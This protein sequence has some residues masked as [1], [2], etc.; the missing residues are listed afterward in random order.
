[1]KLIKN[2][3]NGVVGSDIKEDINEDI[4]Y[5]LLSNNFVDDDVMW[6]LLYYSGYLTYDGNHLFIPN[7][8]V[9]T[10]WMGWIRIK[11]IKNPN[12]LLNMLLEGNLATFEK[13]FP[14]LIM[15]VL[16]YH[17]VRDNLVESN[18]HLFTV[19][20]FAQAQFCGYKVESNK[21]CGLGLFDL[22]LV[23]NEGANYLTSVIIEFKAIK[24]KYHDD[25]EYCEEI[26]SDF[27][28]EENNVES[29]L[30]KK[31]IEGF[32]QILEKKYEFDPN[33][34]S[35]KLVE[36]GIAFC[37]KQVCVVGRVLQRIGNEWKEIYC[38]KALSDH[39]NVNK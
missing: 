4:N 27:N 2:I 14:N 30:Q 7:K 5:D 8:E 28:E 9:F 18:Y 36:C 17:D 6:T 1:V 12:L 16:S 11:G 37:G 38:S 22:K 23:P 39:L 20:L 29:Y 24:S 15:S 10:E 35:T 34:R 26:E 32:K 13:E 19:G 25:D 33:S 31:A 21:E 3:Q